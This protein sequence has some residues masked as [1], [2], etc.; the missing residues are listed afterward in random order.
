MAILS[1]FPRSAAQT[2][3]RELCRFTKRRAVSA[4]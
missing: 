1:T 4:C 2:T 3:M